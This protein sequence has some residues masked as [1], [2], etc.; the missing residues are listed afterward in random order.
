MNKRYDKDSEYFEKVVK[1]VKINDY[2]GFMNSALLLAGFIGGLVYAYF[3][4]FNNLFILTIFFMFLILIMSIWL[5]V[6]ENY[7]RCVK[8]RRIK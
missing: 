1:W 4:T 8:Y 2:N 7:E 6:T 3:E 5:H